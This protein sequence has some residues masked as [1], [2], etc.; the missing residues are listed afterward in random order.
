MRVT[1]SGSSNFT[2]HRQPMII[3]NFKSFYFK[4]SRNRMVVGGSYRSFRN[5][6]IT[7]RLFLSLII[8]CICFLEISAV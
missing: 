4:I 8:L 7:F 2:K 6:V 5:W 3:F 1:G